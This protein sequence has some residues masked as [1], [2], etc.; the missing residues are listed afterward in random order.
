MSIPMNWEKA[1]VSGQMNIQFHDTKFTYFSI[2]RNPDFSNWVPEQEQVLTSMFL[3][4]HQTRT[5]TITEWLQLFEKGTKQNEKKSKLLKE[6]SL[7]THRQILSQVTHH[8]FIIFTFF[9]DFAS[10]TSIPL[11]PFLDAVLNNP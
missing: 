10:K 9:A 4:H 2:S 8:I 1:S 6:L 11:E 3:S 5:V 7:K